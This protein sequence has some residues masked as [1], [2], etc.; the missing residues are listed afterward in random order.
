M[1]RSLMHKLKHRANAWFS[2]PMFIQVLEETGYDIRGQLHEEDHLEVTL[3]DQDTKLYIIQART[4][5][6]VSFWG[7]LTGTHFGEKKRG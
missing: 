3:G 2:V 5:F 4:L 6:L 7:H 1:H